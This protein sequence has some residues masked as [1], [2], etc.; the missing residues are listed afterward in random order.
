[1]VIILQS[2]GFSHEQRFFILGILNLMLFLILFVLF[3][4]LKLKISQYV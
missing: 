2:D 1:M 4:T 3:L